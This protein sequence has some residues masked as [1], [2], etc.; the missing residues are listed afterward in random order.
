MFM[1]QE[2]WSGGL[3]SKRGTAPWGTCRRRWEPQLQVTDEE[4]MAS[5]GKWSPWFGGTWPLCRPGHGSGILCGLR[6]ALAVELTEGRRRG[7]LA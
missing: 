5:E 3:L 1:A 2:Q 7:Q 6:T 4:A